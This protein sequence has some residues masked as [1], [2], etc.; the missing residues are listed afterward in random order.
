MLSV[1]KKYINYATVPAANLVFA[2]QIR[3]CRLPVETVLM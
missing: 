1:I 2:S 3:P